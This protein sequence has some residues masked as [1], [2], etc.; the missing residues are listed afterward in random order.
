MTDLTATARRTAR[1]ANQIDRQIT[2]ANQWLTD[3]TPDGYPTSSS[4]AGTTNTGEPASPT[5]N[6]ITA[7]PTILLHGQPRDLRSI[8]TELERHLD[9]AAATLEHARDILYAIPQQATGKT[10]ALLDHETKH[11]RCEGWA[12]RYAICDDNHVHT[13][14]VNGSTTK[15]CHRCYRTMWQD[16]IGWPTGGRHTAPPIA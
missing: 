5:L 13:T 4:G 6:A 14:V 9:T 15:L 11:A 12:T 7:T 2:T 8:R 3:H 16:T 10:A 1:L